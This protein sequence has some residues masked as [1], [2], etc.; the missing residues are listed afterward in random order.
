VNYLRLNGDGISSSDSSS[1]DTVSISSKSSSSSS[2]SS[3]SEDENL[4]YKN[5]TFVTCRSPSDS[6][7]LCRVLQDVNTHTKRI[8]IRWCSVVGEDGDDT[9]ISINTRFK[10]S[11]VDVLDPHTI[12]TA[13]TDIIEHNDGT[14]SLKKGDIVETKRLLEKSIRGD[15]LSSDDM[16]DLSTEHQSSSKPKPKKHIHFASS[17]ENDSSSDSQSP[18]TSSAESKKR[19]MTSD[20]KTSRKQPVKKRARK[21]TNDATRK[22]SCL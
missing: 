19:K 20:K 6:F 18:T 16:M 9:Q 7:Y 10:L 17:G 2:S 14:L 11:Y 5:Q 15:T 21:T 1:E 8:R 12:L 22:F 4:L 3:S 13:I